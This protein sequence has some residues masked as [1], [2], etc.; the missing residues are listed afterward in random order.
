M[1]VF[2]FWLSLKP[3]WCDAIPKWTIL[4]PS[5]FPA[6][7]TGKENR[8]N[9]LNEHKEQDKAKHHDCGVIYLHILSY[10]RHTHINI[11]VHMDKNYISPLSAVSLDIVYMFSGKI[12]F[13]SCFAWSIC[14]SL[15][16]KKHGTGTEVLIS[17]KTEKNKKQSWI[18]TR[19][20]EFELIRWYYSFYVSLLKKIDINI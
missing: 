8:N 1:I 7:A 14:N 2:E 3:C 20:G 9:K 11:Y 16:T 13:R 4:S 19:G 5:P 17:Q 10:L 6:L 12:F 15:S 18:D